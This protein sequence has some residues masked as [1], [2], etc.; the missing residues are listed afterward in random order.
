MKRFSLSHG[1]L[2]GI[3]Q[4]GATVI[5]EVKNLDVTLEG[6][7]GETAKIATVAVLEISQVWLTKRLFWQLDWVSPD[8]IDAIA[9]VRP[10]ASWHGSNIAFAVGRR[11]GSNGLVRSDAPTHDGIPLDDDCPPEWKGLPLAILF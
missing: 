5:A 2:P 11:K 10:R 6:D 8:G 7:A 1:Q 4:K 9:R 3:H